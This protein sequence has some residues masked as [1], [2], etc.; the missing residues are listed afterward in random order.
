M[1]YLSSLNEGVTVVFGD[2]LHNTI[3]WLSIYKNQA[4]VFLAITVIAGAVI[5]YSLI[6]FLWDRYV[7]LT[8]PKEPVS[9]SRKRKVPG[10]MP[11]AHVFQAGKPVLDKPV[12]ERSQLVD[13]RQEP[14]AGKDDLSSTDNL[15]KGIPKEHA[16]SMVDAAPRLRELLDRFLGDYNP[17]HG[18]SATGELKKR[19]KEEHRGIVFTLVASNKANTWIE[20][21]LSRTGIKV[22]ASWQK[23][24]VKS[25]EGGSSFGLEAMDGVEKHLWGLIRTLK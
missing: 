10:T 18:L 1:G 25:E 11:G 4:V 21:L 12:L 20:V 23:A 8:T 5:L 6:A 9:T 17:V 16:I 22:T 2:L 3:V 19:E 14:A 24:P 13:I 7:P 15:G